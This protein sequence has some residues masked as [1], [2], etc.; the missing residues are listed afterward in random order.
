MSPLT[1]FIDVEGVYNFHDI[2]AHSKY[3][4][5]IRL[6]FI[7]R[8]AQPYSA[9]AASIEQMR[10]LGITTIFDLRADAEVAETNKVTP[11][12][13]L[14]GLHRVSAPV[15]QSKEMKVADQ[16][17][18]YF[19][20]DTQ[21]MMATYAR[22]LTEGP[23]CFR[24]IF[25]HLRDHA[26]DPCILQCALGKD[27]TGVATALILSLAGVPEQLIA[28]EY[29]L[30]NIGLEAYRPLARK[31]LATF[32]GLDW[33][34]DK[35]TAMLSVRYGRGPLCFFARLHVHLC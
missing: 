20:N 17:M 3:G 13:E 22:M 27:R 28:E 7:F 8:S 21:T 2:A 30:T 31:F 33:D 14:E 34:E 9:T 1:T 4:G 24:R 23:D 6:G 35:I 25:C 5:N 32:S 11:L 29:A 16:L 18:A 19:L 10:R 26:R 15:F 12:R